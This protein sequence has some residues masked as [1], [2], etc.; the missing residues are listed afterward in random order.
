MY[1][2]CSFLRSHIRSI[3]DF[4]LPRAID[5]RAGGFFGGLTDD[6]TIYDPDTRHLVDTCRHIYN[7]STA[8][9][10]FGEDRFAEAAE[11]GLKFLDTAHRLPQGGFAWVLENRRIEDATRHCYGH[12]FVLLAASAAAKAGLSEA[13]AL[14]DET[15][16]ILE[17]RFFEPEA[18]LYADQIGPSSWSDVDSY[19]GQNANMHL[20]EAMLVAYEATG[21]SRFLDRAETLARRICLELAAET[22]GLVWE[23][24]RRDWSV[25]WDYN[26]EDPKN[27]FRPYGYLPGHFVEWTKLLVLLHRS[28]PEGWMLDRARALFDAALEHGWD[29]ERGGFNYTF[30][31]DGR[32]LDTDRYYWVL[33]EAIAAAALL[34][35]ALGVEAVWQWYDR[36]WEYSGNVL[37]DH[38]HG[39]WYRVTDP[40]GKPYDELKSP[41]AKTDYHPLSACAASLLA[42]Q[43]D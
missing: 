27:L 11:H 17:E 2:E 19:R 32:I 35:R 18:G 30:A 34:G 41:P 39:G 28:R 9:V 15:W 29:S 21:D 20:C 25:D 16:K 37:I 24:Y 12:A 3:L 38:K 42:L 13:A 33:S 10:L 1:R 4:Y 40:D 43:P 14:V 23:H 22:D 7:Y 26:R 31:P 5:R 8:I 6:G 36:F